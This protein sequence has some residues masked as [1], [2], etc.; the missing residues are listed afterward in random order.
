MKYSVGFFGRRLPPE[1]NFRL[2]EIHQ[3]LST[4]KQYSIKLIIALVLLALCRGT[5]AAAVATVTV[6][7]ISA[8]VQE[9][10]CY[11]GIYGSST[12]LTFCRTDEP[13]QIYRPCVI[14]FEISGSASA[15]DYGLSPYSHS[16]TLRPEEQCATIT[17]TPSEDFENE[18]TET[19]TIT[20]TSVQVS[21]SNGQVQF[22]TG[23]FDIGPPATISILDSWPNRS[24]VISGGTPPLGPLEAECG[25]SVEILVY[26]IAL[27]GQIDAPVWLSGN[28]VIGQDYDITYVPIC[29][30]GGFYAMVNGYYLTV[31]DT[32]MCPPNSP[33]G[34]LVV[35]TQCP[36][37]GCTVQGDKLARITVNFCPGPSTSE[38]LIKAPPSSSKP[39]PEIVIDMA[40]SRWDCNDLTLNWHIENGPLP[41]GFTI[42]VEQ[43][44][45]DSGLWY[46]ISHNLN[47]QLFLTPNTFC[48]SCFRIVASSPTCGDIV[49]DIACIWRIPCH[50]FMSWIWNLHHPSLV[51]NDV[52]GANFFILNRASAPNGPFT[53]VSSGPATSF[54]VPDPCGVTY[55]YKIVAVSLG[56][57]SDES[58]VLAVPGV[59]CNSA[60]PSGSTTISL[61]WIP[62]TPPP[63]GPYSPSSLSHYKVTRTVSSGGYPAV[64]NVA[65]P[66]LV[67]ENLPAGQTYQYSVAA[68]LAGGQ[69]V[70]LTTTPITVDPVH[71]LN[72]EFDFINNPSSGG[73][74][75]AGYSTTVGGQFVPNTY[76]TASVLADNGTP[77]PSWRVSSSRSPAFYRNSTSQAITV[78][79]GAATLQPGDIWVWPGD[80][81]F[82]ENYAVIRYR[83]PE[84]EA[85]IYQ[86]LAHVQ[87]LYLTLFSSGDTDFHVLHNGI[88]IYG[89]S[90]RAGGSAGIVRTLNLAENDTVEFV[91]GRGADGSQSSSSLKLR[92]TL[93]KVAAP[94]TPGTPTSPNYDFSPASNPFPGGRWAVG[95]SS[96]I[97]ST[98][99]LVGYM[100]SGNQFDGG[101]LLSS[102]HPAQWRSPS[103]YYNSAPQTVTAGGITTF[104]PKTLWVVAGDNGYPENYGVV[105]YTVPAGQAGTFA[106]GAVIESVYLTL[107]SGDTDFH[108]LKN[109]VPMTDVNVPAKGSGMRN[110][111]AYLN[112]GDTIS[113][114]VG[115]GLDGNQY[116]SGLKIWTEVVRL[117]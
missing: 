2:A 100:Y 112:D 16:V 13:D 98:F 4:M 103:F 62:Y 80:N 52:F 72:Q 24:L 18:P 79:G 99:N 11:L 48:S 109:G 15:G 108:I 83:V 102:W 37:P 35:T 36:P 33:V 3:Q 10:N 117:P 20:I 7:P 63:S 76:Y 97:G 67:N 71:S 45:Y 115:R 70:P 23:D 82:P 96:T 49:S 54:P 84:G 110:H 113:L 39:K 116:A 77:I 8:D 78:G 5:S 53:P 87:A 88:E 111:V 64:Y 66:E 27:D 106:I 69:E 12:T 59:Q 58:P 65:N 40:T 94:G 61:K 85:G 95:W 46:T 14:T 9:P 91:I 107:S 101:T 89:N 68:V 47:G 73:R 57:Q 50:P 43:Y 32:S 55:Y 81:G 114:V 86:L 92:A 6:S 26:A 31:Y 90:L 29:A 104:V 17:L 74:W 25:Q 34:K 22:T 75:T 51:W 41:P 105:R 1:N 60:P 93:E 56:G 44:D 28:A 38:V 42:R 19:V 21:H 30:D